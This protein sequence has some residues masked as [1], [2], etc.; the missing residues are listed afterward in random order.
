MRNKPAKTER[1]VST[2]VTHLIP[3][4]V[5]ADDNGFHPP[6]HQPGN[7]LADNRLSEDSAT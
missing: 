4:S 3:I 5:T 6:R 2:G 7:V 1:G